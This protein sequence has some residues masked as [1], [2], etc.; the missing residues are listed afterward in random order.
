MKKTWLLRGIALGNLLLFVGLTL[1]S[2]L[3][4]NIPNLW[5]YS[6]C[7]C[8][9]AY[10]LS[11]GL[12]FKLDSAIY[13]GSLLTNIGANGFIFY[14]MD[15]RNYAIF[16]IAISFVLA[17]LA[18]FILCHQ[19]FHLILAYSISFLSL[20]AYLLSKSL[21]TTPIFIAFGCVFLVQLTVSII[22]NIK[23]GI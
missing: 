3:H 11:R 17:S 5:F 8:I 1:M 13:L 14:L 23:K 19:K 2:F 12:L 4:L 9:G 6:F 15:L 7:L 20:Y 22:L 21:I 16:F 18:T 10:E